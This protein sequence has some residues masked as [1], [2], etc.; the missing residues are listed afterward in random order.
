MKKAFEEMGQSEARLRKIID[1]IPTLV[2]CGLPDG[3]ME[4]FNQRWRDYTGLS[5]EEAR[6]RG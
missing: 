5:P 1:T 2:W 4:L 3:S 6:G